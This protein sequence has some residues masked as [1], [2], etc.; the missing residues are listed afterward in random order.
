MPPRSLA[1]AAGAKTTWLLPNSRFLGFF[2]NGNTTENDTEEKILRIVTDSQ[3]DFKSRL[4]KICEKV[5]QKL[6]AL[7]RT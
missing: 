7:A 6:I 1:L 5:N 2:F 3:L 4:K